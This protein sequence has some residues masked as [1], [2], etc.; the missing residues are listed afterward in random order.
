V[1]YANSLEELAAVSISQDDRGT[2]QAPRRSERVEDLVGHV[3]SVSRDLL[4]SRTVSVDP[5]GDSCSQVD[6]LST[7]ERLFRTCAYAVEGFSP[8]GRFAIGRPAYQS[9]IGDGLVAILDARTGQ[10]L[11]EYRNDAESQAFITGRAWD[12]DGTLLATVVSGER[13]FLMRM[14]VDGELSHATL[15]GRSEW[16][17]PD[18]IGIP[19]RFPTQ[20]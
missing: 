19:V 10:P 20:P 14:T 6:A 3:R 8:D 7:G 2:G 15:D 13:T 5:Q 9:G 18:G 11:V 16:P 17:S 1:V 12:G 4:L